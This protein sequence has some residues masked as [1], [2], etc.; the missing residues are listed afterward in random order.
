MEPGLVQRG[1][2]L[3]ASAV[4]SALSRSPAH[5]HAFDAAPVGTEPRARG[6]RRAERGALPIR[7]RALATLAEGTQRTSPRA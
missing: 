2:R 3:T 4:S 5:G 1:L 6:E 7:A